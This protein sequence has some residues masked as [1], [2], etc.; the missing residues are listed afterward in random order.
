MSKSLGNTIEPQKV[1]KDSGADILRLWV[2]SCDYTD[3][4]RIGPEILKNTVETYRKLRNTI[5][6]MLGT[7]HHFKRSE[8]VAHE[9][10]P[11]L[12][13][14]MLHQL[15][16]QA[17]RRAAGLCRIRLQDGGRDACGLHEHRAVG[18][19]FRYPQGHALL[20]SA[21]VGGAQGGADHDRHH[22]RLDPEMAGA[23]VEL[24]RRGGLAD[25]SQGCRTLGA[26][27]AV[28]DRVRRF[29]RRGAGGEMGHHPQ[30]PPRRH[31]RAR[32]RTRRQEDRLLAGGLADRLRRRQGDA[33]HAV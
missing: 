28:P 2:A 20:R 4:Q 24:H 5:R 19:L 13:R 29:P 9:D 1:I 16:E 3:D 32:A 25:V 21:I 12:E 23:G 7:L 18:V 15:A 33:G 26:P 8:A 30:R 11:E 17:Q 6:W 31:R 22:L 14:L 27:G 10:M